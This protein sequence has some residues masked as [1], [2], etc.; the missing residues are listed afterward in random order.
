MSITKTIMK[1]KK[2]FKEKFPE[3]NTAFYISKK[4]MCVHMGLDKSIFSYT[5]FEQIIGQITKFFNENLVAKFYVNYTQLIHTT[6]W[7]YDY[8]IHCCFISSVLRNERLLDNR[9]KQGNHH[10]S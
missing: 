1:L 3:L 2:Q 10:C 7:K 9:G 6:K 5:N 4:N 8:I